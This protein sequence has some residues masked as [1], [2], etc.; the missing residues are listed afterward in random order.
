MAQQNQ[1]GKTAPSNQ[2]TS[3]RGLSGMDE[4]R[5]NKSGG[6]T[7]SDKTPREYNADTDTEENLGNEGANSGRQEI[8]SDSDLN[9]AQTQQKRPAS[10]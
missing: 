4:S 9:R 2:E 7:F 8:Q 10:R 6:N 5:P 3:N 1:P